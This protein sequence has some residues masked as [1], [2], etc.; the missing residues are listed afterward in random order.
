MPLSGL[1]SS[2]LVLAACCAIVG[3]A[4]AQETGEKPPAAVQTAAVKLGEVTR[5]SKFVGTVQA[6]QQV[7]LMARVEGFLDSVNFQ[8]GS[9]VE[10]GSLAFGIE[11]DTYQAALAGAQATLQAAQATEVGAEANLKQA[12]ITLDRQVALLRTKD[13]PQST[14]D[15]ATA[16]RDTASASVGQA[17]AQIAQAQAQV[18]TA[19]LNLSYTDVKTPI[20]GRI[21]K[22]QITVGN[23]VSPSSGTLATVVQVDP[24]RVVFSISDREYLQVVNALKPNAQ[25]LTG[26]TKN[27][28]PSLTLSDGTAYAHPGKI[29]F[30]DNTIDPS[31][32]TIAVYAEFPNPNLQLVPGQFVSVSVQVGQPEELPLV[33]ASAVQQ[34]KDGAY[35]FVLGDGNRAIIRRVTLGQRVGVDW[36]IQS[37]LV[38]GEVIIVSGIQRIQAGVV[39]N[40]TPAE[41][42]N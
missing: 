29:G 8:E 34:D 24:I 11:K 40:P 28:Q 17:Q 38:A 20:S 16:T 9:Y 4:S 35:V 41:T 36:S 6:V 37:G 3:S 22:A 7:N 39:V 32:G 31:T 23:L 1:R 19:D 33:P 2:L 15:Q 14:V 21:G 42:G 12:Q 5:Q 18:R 30:I 10:A 25:G 27:Y 13:V 26:D